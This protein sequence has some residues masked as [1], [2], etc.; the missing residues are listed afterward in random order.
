MKLKEPIIKVINEAFS[1]RKRIDWI[2]QAK[3]FGIILVVYG[4]NFPVIE[5]YI[6]SFHMPLFFIIAGIFHPKK[7]NFD[8]VKRRVR[9]ILVPY[10]LWS[11]ILFLFW[12]VIG[13][14]FGESA[15]LELSS[16][17]N[18]L[19]I[20][21]AQGDKEYMNWGIPM[22]FLPCLF[23]TFLLFWLIR[24]IVKNTAIR[25]ILIITCVILGF[26]IPKL[27]DVSFFWSLDV[28]FVSL[29]FY[30]FGYYSKKYW[31]YT[32]IK[33]E[34]LFTFLL[35]ILHIICSIYFLQKVDMYRSIY[36][37]EFFFIFNSI[38]GV[39]FWCQLIKKF[40]NLKALAF[41]GKNTIPVLAMQV[42][43]LT[44]IK[45]ILFIFIGSSLF[46]FSELEKIILV[47]FQLLLMYPIILLINKHLPIL[48]GKN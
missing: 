43:S 26:L 27:T 6:Y 19:G 37:N 11:F 32:E 29:L 35:L 22:W 42:R 20:F 1:N 10:F 17:K 30:A 21:Y 45:L 33:R 31:V 40:K 18:F 13:R 15:S 3:G 47:V 36:G 9:Q 44:F 46:D 7:S 41:L 14:K 25:L 38:I 5:N 8:V 23:L 24:K 28:A 48:N 2:D 39:L 12:F 4:H 34:Y 16:L